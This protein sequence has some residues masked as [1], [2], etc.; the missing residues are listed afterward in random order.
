MGQVERQEYE[1]IRHGLS[2]LDCKLAGGNWHRAHPRACRHSLRKPMHAA[3]I[4]Q[5][6]ASDTKAGWIFILDQLNTH[7]SETLV[8]LVDRLCDLK[9]DLGEKKQS[10][11][12]KSMPTR[13]AFLSDPNHRIP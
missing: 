12:L 1:Y 3:H 10:V 9:L 4:A 6:I 7:K 13:A 8:R 2:L 11:I 5:T